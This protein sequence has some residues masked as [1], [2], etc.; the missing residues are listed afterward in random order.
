MT[1]KRKPRTGEP[2]RIRWMAALAAALGACGWPVVN[3]R[4]PPNRRSKCG[5]GRST[6]CW[7]RPSTSPGSPARKTVKQVRE[8]HPQEPQAEGKG[9]EGID[10]KRPFGLTRR[11]PTTSIQS[12]FIV[13]VPIADQER[14]LAMLKERLEITPEKVDGA[15]YKS[16]CPRRPR[17]PCSTRSTSA[18]PTVT[19]TSGVPRPTSTRKG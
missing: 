8:V 11:S 2:M 9:I 19:C 15:H 5:S 10:P 12:P 6:I 3:G 1:D 17:T 16:I 7:T 18:S 14:F 13:M 4:R